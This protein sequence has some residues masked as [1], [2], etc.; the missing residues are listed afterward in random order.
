MH[1]TAP[2]VAVLALAAGAFAAVAPKE[3]EPPVNA[4][5]AIK[6]Q[7]TGV[8]TGA[9]GTGIQTGTHPIMTGTPNNGTRINN[10]TAVATSTV[11]CF[12]CQGGSSTIPVVVPSRTPG[13]SAGAG[14]AGGAV[15]SAGGAGGASNTPA[16]PSATG[17]TPSN[18]GS[19]VSVPQVGAAGAVM[20]YGL[21]LLA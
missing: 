6:K 21:M 19:K 16:A 8:A 12:T 1:F 20:V 15:P 9:H 13:A 5:S 10:S 11:P 3:L 18:P 4:K 7:A 14:G 2:S 17:F